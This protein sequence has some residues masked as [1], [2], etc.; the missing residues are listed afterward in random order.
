M[1][2]KTVKVIFLFVDFSETFD[3]IHREKMEPILLTYGVPNETVTSIIVATL[4][5]ERH[6]EHKKVERKTYICYI[7]IYSIITTQ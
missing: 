4:A 6:G 7:L 3:S 5:K 1:S 2:A